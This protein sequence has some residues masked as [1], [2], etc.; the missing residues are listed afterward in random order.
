M[1]KLR[2]YY[3]KALKDAEDKFIEIMSEQIRAVDNAADGGHGAPEWKD[4]LIKAVR[5]LYRDIAD[6]Y[7]EIGVG[8]P[9]QGG[10]DRL[11]VEAMIY[12][13]GVGDK[14]DNERRMPPVQTRPG[15]E[16]WKTD[17]SRDTSRATAW[18]DIPQFNQYGTHYIENSIK[19]MAKH[20]NDVLDN[21]A[22]NLPDDFFYRSVVSK[23][24]A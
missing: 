12:E 13:Y 1:N 18:Y 16:V 11:S 21:A 3:V 22:A 15:E 9:N 5:T 14:S 8:I 23:K 19:L 24:G 6:N 7:I 10:R 4:P 20:F 17:M 2:A